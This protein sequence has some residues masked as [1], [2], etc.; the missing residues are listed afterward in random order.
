MQTI[1]GLRE[2]EIHFWLKGNNK[3]NRKEKSK[4]IN[5]LAGYSVFSSSHYQGMLTSRFYLL[6]FIIVD[7]RLWYLTETENREWNSVVIQNFG[8]EEHKSLN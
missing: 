7:S 6:D 1:R 2:T 4:I 3:G 8:I 5:P